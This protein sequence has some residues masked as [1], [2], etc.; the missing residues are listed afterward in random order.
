MLYE[1][2]VNRDLPLIQGVTIVFAVLFI[3]LNLVI[4]V[5]Y[6]FINPR[7]RHL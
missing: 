7:V 2:A 6:L 1:A 4:D 3:L 5:A